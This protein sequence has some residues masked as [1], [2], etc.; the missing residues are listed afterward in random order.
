MIWTLFH[1]SL[2]RPLSLSLS[3]ST[4]P[5]SLSPLSFLSFSFR[6]SLPPSLTPSLLFY[7]SPTSLPSLS[8][9]L[10]LSLL[11]FLSSYCV[12]QI[13][14]GFVSVVGFTGWNLSLSF[15][16]F[17]L[18]WEISNV[19][20]LSQSHF[21]FPYRIDSPSDGICPSIQ[22]LGAEYIPMVTN[23]SSL[24]KN[25]IYKLNQHITTSLALYL[26]IHLLKRCS[27]PLS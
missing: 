11:S 2:C 12:W 16:F 1:S 25:V 4:P 15:L 3:P 7:F 18:S 24:S 6:T 9:C 14:K 19:G 17:F 20:I 26:F 21:Y 10:C 13:K 22:E 5:L 27:F 8:I 23:S